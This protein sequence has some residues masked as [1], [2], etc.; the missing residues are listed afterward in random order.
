MVYRPDLFGWKILEPDPC[1]ILYDIPGIVDRKNPSSIIRR[2]VMSFP[3]KIP[4]MDLFS[5]KIFS[6]FFS[7]IFP[8]SKNQNFFDCLR[9]SFAIEKRFGASERRI[10]V[11]STL[12]AFFI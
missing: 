10:M 3:I 11:Y 9:F 2:V 7:K 4:A 5:L 12:N 1:S 8:I 6:S